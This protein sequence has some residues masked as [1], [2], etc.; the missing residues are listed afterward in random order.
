MYEWR[1]LQSVVNLPHFDLMSNMS[2]EVGC[3][4]PVFDESTYSDSVESPLSICKSLTSTAGVAAVRNLSELVLTC[5]IVSAFSGFLSV[6][7]R[8]TARILV[9]SRLP[10]ELGAVEAVP[11]RLPAVLLAEENE[12]P[13]VDVLYDVPPLEPKVPGPSRMEVAFIR[14]P[15]SLS[16]RSVSHV[17]R[18]VGQGLDILTLSSLE[19]LPEP[20][21]LSSVAS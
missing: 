9:H 10:P 8:L 7:C 11:R 15:R 16:W 20:L 19:A 2:L 3:C 14:T 21:V 17:S 18:H 4:G 12:V 1:V 13:F 6:C 5:V